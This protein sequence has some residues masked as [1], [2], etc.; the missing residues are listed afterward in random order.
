MSS[1]AAKV[2]GL[3]LPR[4]L[5]EAQGVASSGILD[6]VNAVEKDNLNLHSIMVD[7]P[8]SISANLAA[9]RVKDLLTMSTGHDTDSADWEVD[10]SGINTG[11]W[12]G[13]RKKE[14]NDWL[15]GYGYQFWR[16]RHDGYRGDGAY[17]QY[18][19]VLPKEDLVVAITSETA[20]MQGILDQ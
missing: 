9:M 13:S 17:G 18:C 16:C 2:P 19:I 4:S 10:P 15:Q 6:F 20:D 12:G 7:V 3:Q 8:A 1:W 5:P 11:G 14:Q